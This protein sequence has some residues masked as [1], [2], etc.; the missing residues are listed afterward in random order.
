[1]QEIYTVY[2]LLDALGRIVRV[3]SDATLTDTDGW[4]RIDAGAGDRYMH[5]Q[6]NYLPG[7]IAD[8]RGIPR[9]KMADGAVTAR[10]QAEMDADAPPVRPG[11]A[12]RIDALEAAFYALMGGVQDAQ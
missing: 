5:A 11:D 9:Y 8:G 3:E 6:G 12:S 7:G 4:V 10:T 1:M 2:A